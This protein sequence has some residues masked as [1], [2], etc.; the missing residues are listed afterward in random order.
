M[1]SKSMIHLT[2]KPL[3]VFTIASIILMNGMN[4]QLGAGG[5]T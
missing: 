1:I 4:G 2:N 5:G 3:V